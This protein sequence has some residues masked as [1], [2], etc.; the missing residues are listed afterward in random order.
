MH[1]ASVTEAIIKIVLS[2]AEK[3][4][5]D[6]V[7]VVRVVVGEMTGYVGDS[8]Q[9]YFDRYSQGSIAEGARVETSYVKA[10][11]KCA[12]CGKLQER[13]AFSLSCDACGGDLGPTPI[14]TEFYLESIEVEK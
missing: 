13:R 1:E 12:S 4:C 5:A 10:L 3:A 6:R 9:F 8:I 14:G 7:T 2:E 11:S